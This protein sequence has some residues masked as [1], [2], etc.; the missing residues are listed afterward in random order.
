MHVCV[1]RLYTDKH[2]QNTNTTVVT[3]R[4][5]GETDI[6]IS[7]VLLQLSFNIQALAHTRVLLRFGK[8]FVL[9]SHELHRVNTVDHL[10]K[11]S[12]L[13]T[14]FLRPTNLRSEWMALTPWL[15]LSLFDFQWGVN[16]MNTSDQRTNKQTKKTNTFWQKLMHW[17]WCFFLS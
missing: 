2:T 7:V 9:H 14:V 8:E 10:R 4:Y 16:V 17:F 12:D 3:G 6:S 11:S 13:E 5:Q 1:W 15:L